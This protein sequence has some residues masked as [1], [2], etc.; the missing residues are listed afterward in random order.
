MPARAS[1]TTEGTDWKSD[2]AGWP[3]T[4]STAGKA[5]KLLARKFLAKGSADCL[6][7]PQ[8]SQ[9]ALAAAKHDP[10]SAPQR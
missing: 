5:K 1:A 6:A 8:H 2:R 9:T 4:H 7:S 10:C 3:M